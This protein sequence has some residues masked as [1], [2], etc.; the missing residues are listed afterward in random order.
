[1]HKFFVDNNQ[2]N[3]S[4]I[5]IKNDD[6]NHIVKVLRK[7]I[8]DILLISNK[9]TAE[10]FKCKIEEITGTKIICSIIE[11]NQKNTEMRIKIDIYQGLPKADKMEYIIQKSVELG[12]NAIIPVN[13]KYCIAKIKDEDKKINRWNKISEVA[14]KQSKR[15]IVPKIGKLINFDELYEKIKNYDLV[16]VAY[17]NE[18]KTTI[19]EILKN[20]RNSRNIA[21]V[22]GPEGGISKEE[23]EK[24][25]QVGAI[26]VSLG[27]RILRTETAP[28]A[29][30]SMIMYEYEF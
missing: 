15:N 16:I 12:A 10:T 2:I 29:V 5:E 30:L 3:N 11:E 24:L 18:D 19:K 27:K 1:M 7:K 4:Y 17:E 22:I 25:Q 23:I 8:G 14:A 9:M 13:M 21:V 28:I 20:K 26:T 6:Y